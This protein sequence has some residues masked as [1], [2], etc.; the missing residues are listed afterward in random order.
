MEGTGFKGPEVW[1]AS[2][3]LVTELCR[4]TANF[5]DSE[6]YGLISQIRR[7]A[8]SIPT[9]IAEGYGRKL[10]ASYAYFLRIAKGST[11]E[12]ETLLIVSHRLGFATDI[13]SLS[14]EVSRVGAMLTGLLRQVEQ[15]N[16]RDHGAFYLSGS[17]GEIEPH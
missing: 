1:K 3:D 4:L 10:A 6:R 15:K 12:I 9:N 7:A 13:R 16:V 17:A 8:I 11:N 5:P 2:M 14:E